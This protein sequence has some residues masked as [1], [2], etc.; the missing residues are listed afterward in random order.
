[1]LIKH[2]EN[3]CPVFYQNVINLFHL[4][5][6]FLLMNFSQSIYPSSYVYPSIHPVMSI[7]IHPVMSISSHL[8]MSAHPSIHPVMSTIH[9]SS[10]VYHPVM[11]TIHPSSYVYHPSIQLCLPS[12]HTQGSK[13]RPF[14]SHMRPKCNLCDSKIYLGAFV[15]VQ[16]IVVVRPLQFSAKRSRITA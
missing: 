7:S 10:Y 14:W 3:V 1:M 15:R 11:F 4:N 2:K 5:F 8:V 12:I 6:T 16:I 9:P 13:L